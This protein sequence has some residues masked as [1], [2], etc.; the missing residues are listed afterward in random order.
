MNWIYSKPIID[1]K[2]LSIP[3]INNELLTI[4]T[5]IKSKSLDNKK[6][7][8]NVFL[9]IDLE[10]GKLVWEKE[11]IEIKDRPIITDNLLFF[12][13]EM[14]MI[15]VLDT[16]SGKEVT[17]SYE[18]I[19]NEG[20]QIKKLNLYKDFVFSFVETPNSLVFKAFK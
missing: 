5:E 7:T 18:A 10:S 4:K 16:L 15:S 14:G 2:V 13:N 17:L 8:K 3:S 20:S 11:I 1:L 19:T 9:G 12:I 6:I